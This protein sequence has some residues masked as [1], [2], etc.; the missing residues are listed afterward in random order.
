MVCNAGAGWAGAFA[1]MPLREVDELV[2][3]NLTAPMELARLLLPGMIEERR[4]HVVFVS[5]IAR[6]RR[7]GG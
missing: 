7:G 4:G 2:A 5:S 3:V 1:G 6:R